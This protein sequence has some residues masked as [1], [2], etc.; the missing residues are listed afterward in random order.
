MI[1][2][3]GHTHTHTHNNK[4]LTEYIHYRFFFLVCVFIAHTLFLFFS[5][6][7][8]LGSAY[9][10]GLLS[11][12]PSHP[13]CVCVCV[14]VQFINSGQTNNKYTTKTNFT[15]LWTIDCLVPS[16]TSPH[17]LLIYY[18]LVSIQILDRTILHKTG[19]E[20]NKFQF[21]IAEHL[22]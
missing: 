13:I 8:S 5:F 21:P 4:S 16:S 19:M 18:T 20:N 17:V 14:Y 6:Y 10:I 3:S 22:L 1:C 11:R 2:D 9:S 7:L 12:P 15:T